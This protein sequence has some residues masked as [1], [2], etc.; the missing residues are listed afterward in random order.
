VTAL[1]PGV[2]TIYVER[3]ADGVAPFLVTERIEVLP[4]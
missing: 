3:I 1:Q 2:A 4:R